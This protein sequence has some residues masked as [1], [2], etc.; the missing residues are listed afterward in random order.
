LIQSIVYYK[1]V[2]KLYSKEEIKW[3]QNKHNSFILSER[4][5][6]I[7]SKGWW[8]A[9]YSIEEFFQSG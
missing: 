1:A 8:I 3:S 2:H 6:G 4:E 9:E 5:K 7:K